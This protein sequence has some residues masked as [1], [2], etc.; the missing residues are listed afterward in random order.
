M[1]SVVFASVGVFAPRT[2]YAIP[3]WP[4]AIAQTYKYMLEKLE[5]IL[6]EIKSGTITATISL[7]MMTALNQL[8]SD[9]GGPIGSWYDY[10]DD[11]RERALHNTLTKM[12][13]DT[14]SEVGTAA[15][16]QD[17]ITARQ[18]SYVRTALTRDS[19]TGN[20]DVKDFSRG[21]DGPTVDPDT[22][23]VQVSNI[24]A[25]TKIFSSP[26]STFMLAQRAEDQKEEEERIE[27]DVAFLSQT[28]AGIDS[29]NAVRV[30]GKV[31]TQEIAI[32]NLI[33]DT[34]KQGTIAAAIAR[35][36]LGKLKSSLAN[37]V[38]SNVEDKAKSV[39]KMAQ[40]A[41]GADVLKRSF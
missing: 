22:G 41:L 25:Y 12:S 4:D 10:L 33:Y 14:I 39:Q 16:G 7:S 23:R 5:K 9:A 6:E 24:A 28:G 18:Q 40:N 36:A 8:L 19:T 20:S 38:R 30:L 37:T 34:S 15:I 3:P 26:D 29:P 31:N 35:V 32:S 2:A 17:S 21:V 13:R 11:T 1:C 27:R